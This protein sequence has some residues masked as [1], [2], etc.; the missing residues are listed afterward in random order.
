MEWKR[1]S[2]GNIPLWMQ[3]TPQNERTVSSLRN[4]AISYISDLV[5][6]R[7]LWKPQP[8]RSFNQRDFWLD[9]SGLTRLNWGINNWRNIFD[10]SMLT[11][12]RQK[13]STFGYMLVSL[14]T[15][16]SWDYISLF[17]LRTVLVKIPA[18]VWGISSRYLYFCTAYIQIITGTSSTVFLSNS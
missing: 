15:P 4:L 12:S 9:G 7:E 2:M 3:W 11:T 17:L 5:Q 8:L 14:F 18:G 1:V 16:T 10:P 6:K 13:Q